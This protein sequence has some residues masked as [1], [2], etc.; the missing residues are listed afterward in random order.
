M[1][2]NIQFSLHNL[3][4]PVNY[5]HII[6][7]FIFDLI[8]DTEYRSFVHNKGFNYKK[9]KYKLFSF[10]RLNGKFYLNKK[11]KTI[12]FFD[13]V[14]LKISSHD[15]NLINYCADSLLFK[16]EFEL[17]GQKI[18][19]EKLEFDDQEINKDKIKVKTLSP[20]T[21]YSTIVENS[22]KKTVYFSPREDK[23]SQLIKENLIK[24]YLAYYDSDLPKDI[25][26]DELVIKEV[27]KKGSKMIITKYKNF[28]IKA[29]DGVFEIQGNPSLLK[30]GYDS[31]FGAKNSQGF[32]LVEVL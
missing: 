20:I 6:Q 8:D 14:S 22:S 19:V 23:F 1:R 12:E 7:A 31:G 21:V 2:L 25:Y 3:I 16:T 27:N 4:L 26:N 17:L 18:F 32:G 30:I 5:N 11:E 29:W 15:K 13:K 9:R 28:I 10:S 24:K